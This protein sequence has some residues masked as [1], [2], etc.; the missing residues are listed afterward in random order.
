VVRCKA[1][2]DTEAW[3]NDNKDQI[4]ADFG[5]LYGAQMS[6]DGI[7]PRTGE[8]YPDMCLV[9]N[10]A[11]YTQT[12]EYV[13]SF[14]Y[15][16]LTD[17]WTKEQDDEVTSTDNGLRVLERSEVAAIDTASPYDEDDVGV[18]TITD[19]GKTLYLAS[20]QD[21]TGAD[22]NAQVGRVVTGWIE[23][24]ILS[25]SKRNRSEGVVEVVTTFLHTEG[26]TVGPVIA[27]STSE[28]E[29]LQTI[30]VTT[31]QDANG[32]SI[33][34]GG[35]NTVHQYNRMV[36]FTYPGVV[37]IGQDKIV[38]GNVTTRLFNFE[39]DPPVQ[40]Q[41]EATVSVIFQTSA[42][43]VSSDFTFNDGSG[44]A[45]GF[46]N[47]TNWASTYLSG[48][49]WNYSPFSET[50]GLRGYRINTDISEI[51][52]LN[53]FGTITWRSRGVVVITNGDSNYVD[54]SNNTTP[55]SLFT[56][57]AGISDSTGLRM[58]ANGK[59]LYASTPFVLEI[60]GGPV[61]PVGNKYTLDVDLRPAFSDIDGNTY[62]KK[63]IITSTIPSQ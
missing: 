29:G 61:D 57:V 39:L 33:V 9:S 45:D 10:S 7:D 63:T 15:E 17:T 37:S 28:F 55:G 6:V 35:S 49:G 58:V 46:W 38:D 44:A 26:N 20:F 50:Q 52:T 24:G 36:P 19:G 23:A 48:I 32:N 59:R 1:A 16:T 14:V 4:F 27:R 8:A 13:I 22:S 40:S 11:S 56:R 42:D 18:A 2:R 31:L 60:F 51:D 12:G 62:Y 41:V 54:P 25:Q 3:Y 47:P 21:Q 5:T 53:P 43:I 34:N 30:S